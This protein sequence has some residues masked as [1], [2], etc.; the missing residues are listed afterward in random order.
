MEYEKIP[1]YEI[2]SRIKNFKKILKENKI[3]AALITYPLN[4]YYFSG[5][6]QDQ[7][8][9]IF[10]DKDPIIFIKRDIKR[11]KE[12]SP[13]SN[14]IKISS[15]KEISKFICTDFLGI[16][17]EYINL[18]EFN[19]LKQLFPNVK[20][21]DISNYITQ[22]RMIKSNV[23]VEYMKKAAEIDKKVFIE[24]LNYLKE[25]MTEIEF[26]GIMEYL[27]KK[28][29]H[30]GI[31]RTGSF[32]F[33]SY[34]WHIMSGISGTYTT[35]TNTPVGGKGLSPAF[36]CGASHK[37]I[38][39]GE[40]IL[41]D[42][43]ICYMGYQVDQTRMFC[44]GEPEDWFVSAYNAIKTLENEIY[45][46]LKI[47]ANG[48]EVFEKVIDKSKELG[49]YDYFLGYNEKFNFIGHGIGLHTSE[50]PFIAKNFNIEIK[51]NM[52]ISFEPKMVLP[53][54]GAIGI[55]NT[56]IVKKEGIKKITI[57]PEEIFYV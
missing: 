29:G 42:F 30:E 43:G 38:K 15:L 25:G 17:Y 56:I 44:I 19:R 32:R 7:Y 27:A 47:G 33:E 36:P 16:E 11:V 41:V 51:E 54:N 10:S 6:N 12:D 46:H 53:K 52:T 3:P 21:T 14:I 50:P 57:T 31:L 1:E 26:A 2:E 45:S 34:T 40:P 18:K 23:E 13:I 49:Y 20:F 4:N 28:Y 5:A 24:S 22:L 8:M 9:I 35:K 48:K 55:E 39:K 37:K